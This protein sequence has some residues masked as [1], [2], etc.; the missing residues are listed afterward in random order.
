MQLNCLKRKLARQ[1]NDL[2]KTATSFYLR[3]P[4]KRKHH[5][6]R[7]LGDALHDEFSVF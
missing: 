1:G 4:R 6:T 5:H 2:L 7:F 3:V